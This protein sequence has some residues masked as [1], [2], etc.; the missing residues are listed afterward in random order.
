MKSVLIGVVS[1]LVVIGAYIAIMRPNVAGPW[2]MNPVTSSTDAAVSVSTDNPILSGWS[3]YTNEALGLRFAYP[4]GDQAIENI[5]ATSSEIQI[6]SGTL[7]EAD[8]NIRCEPSPDPNAVKDKYSAENDL[9]GRGDYGDM[10]REFDTGISPL[11]AFRPKLGAAD[12]LMAMAC[13]AGTNRENKPAVQCLRIRG[14]PST[15]D[16]D[17]YRQ[18]EFVLVNKL[19]PTVKLDP[20]FL[21]S[22]CPG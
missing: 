1:A 15:E 22:S 19:L 5:G 16:S 18:N 21:K 10:L 13:G 7:V 20:A 9:P 12:G 4:V 3:A 11:F 8:F 17:A 6:A 14:V 2:F